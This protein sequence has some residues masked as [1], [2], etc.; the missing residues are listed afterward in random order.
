MT[1]EMDADTFRDYLVKQNGDIFI[2][3]AE[4]NIMSMWPTQKK[5]GIFQAQL[6][7]E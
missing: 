2:N 4:Y 6:Q 1:A 3:A 5:P 7:V